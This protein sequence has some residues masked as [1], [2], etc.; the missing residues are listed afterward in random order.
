MLTPPSG[1]D[2]LAASEKDPYQ[3]L[4]YGNSA[5]S[6]QFHPE[7][8]ADILRAACEDGKVVPDGGAIAAE[9]PWPRRLLHNFCR[10]VEDIG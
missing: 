1:C 3:M 8:T 10:I 2:V 4:R 7:F 6:V 9:T 5:F